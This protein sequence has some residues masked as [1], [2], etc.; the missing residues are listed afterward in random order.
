MYEVTPE[1]SMFQSLES[2]IHRAPDRSRSTIVS[3]AL[4][5]KVLTPLSMNVQAPFSYCHNVPSTRRS[6]I[7]AKVV[8]LAQ[9]VI[10]PRVRVPPAS[11]TWTWKGAMAGLIVATPLPQLIQPVMLC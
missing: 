10:K 9:D 6:T 2:L 1:A 3:F 7:E 4:R 5:L 8:V 11:T